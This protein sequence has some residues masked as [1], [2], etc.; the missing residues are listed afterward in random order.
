MLFDSVTSVLENKP[1]SK[2]YENNALTIY[3][4]YWHYILFQ[5]GCFTSKNMCRENI[6]KKVVC[7]LIFDAVIPM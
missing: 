7:K 2:H 5:E 6:E 3:V 1:S 4:L